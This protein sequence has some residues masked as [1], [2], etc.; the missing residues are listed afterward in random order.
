MKVLLEGGVKTK[1][2]I[3][4]E[5]QLRYEG[6][7]PH[8][9]KY[10]AVCLFTSSSHPRDAQEL[11]PE[12]NQRFMK[13]LNISCHFLEKKGKILQS[14]NLTIIVFCCV[15]DTGTRHT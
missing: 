5:Q 1:S 8:I 10:V 11:S 7:C 12:L 14:K 6:S 3:A 4:S 2:K 13:K 9:Y 15:L